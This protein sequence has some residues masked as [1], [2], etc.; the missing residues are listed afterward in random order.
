LWCLLD[1]NSLLDKIWNSQR[2]E[3]TEVGQ[4]CK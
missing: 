2:R 3:T 4:F 1:Y